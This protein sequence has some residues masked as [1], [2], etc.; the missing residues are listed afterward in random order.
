M[1]HHPHIHMIVLGG[2]L[3]PDGTRWV[4]SRPSFF[5]PVRVL[6]RLFRRLFL[7]M[8]ATAHAEGRLAFF[9]ALEALAV[10][11]PS[12]FPGPR[13]KAR[14]SGDGCAEHSRLGGL[15]TIGVG[16]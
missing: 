16:L 2:G 11:Y 4:P 15:A 14:L 13:G 10:R 3:S 9:G 8:L 7:T 6:S 5:L 1:T 12:M